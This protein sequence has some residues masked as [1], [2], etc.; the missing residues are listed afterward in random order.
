MDIKVV[1]NI[2]SLIL[3]ISF[4]KQSISNEFNM[5]DLYEINFVETQSVRNTADDKSFL[6]R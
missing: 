5:M 6:P 4:F 1:E 2:F 3:S